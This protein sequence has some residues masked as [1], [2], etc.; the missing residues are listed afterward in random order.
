MMT[1]RAVPWLDWAEWESVRSLLVAPEPERRARGV[2]RVAAWRSRGRLPVSVETT[3]CLV[4]V[5]LS[6]RAPQPPSEVQLRLA[7]SMALLRMVNGI[8]D[9]SQRGKA[10]GSVLT[11]ARRLG[12]PPMLVDL[13]H[14]A[15]HGSLPALPAL[16]LGASQAMEWLLERYWQQQHEQATVLESDAA[17]S[18]VRRE[19]TNALKRYRK[20]RETAMQKLLDQGHELGKISQD[21]TAAAETRRCADALAGSTVVVP[22]EA[23]VE[24]FFD[25]NMLVPKAEAPTDASAAAAAGG[26]EEV[27]SLPW[28]RS[29]V[30]GVFNRLRCVWRP[31]LAAVRQ[32][33]PRLRA[34][35]LG[36][37]IDRLAAEG[38]SP[39]TLESDRDA[40]TDGLASEPLP[41][42][43]SISS[44]QR[45]RLGLLQRWAKFLMSADENLWP[46][47]QTSGGTGEA[48]AAGPGNG[49]LIPGRKGVPASELDRSEIISRC[50]H[51]MNEW[52]SPLLS[53]FKRAQQQKQ[54]QLGNSSS[55]STQQQQQHNAR[56]VA[57]SSFGC[58]IASLKRDPT[59]TIAQQ[60][61]A[62]GAGRQSP[63]AAPP[64]PDAI[65]AQLEQWRQHSALRRRQAAADAS[66]A[67]SQGQNGA[68]HSAGGIGGAAGAVGDSFGLWSVPVG[69]VP[70]ALGAP[71]PSAPSDVA[72][73]TDS[74]RA[75]VSAASESDWSLELPEF[76]NDVSLYPCPMVATSM[77]N[78]NP[79]RTGDP[80]ANGTRSAQAGAGAADQSPGSTNASYHVVGQDDPMGIDAAG[81]GGSHGYDLPAP[82]AFD[83]T[84]SLLPSNSAGHASQAAAGGRSAG[85]SAG[86]SWLQ[87]LTAEDISRHSAGASL[88]ECL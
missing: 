52:V 47:L 29:E 22:A 36:A 16:Q 45:L 21:D 11:L 66:G 24:V 79:M 13:R 81:W 2:Q 65:E 14:A 71:A 32:R 72:E 75:E 49:S 73:H 68:E 17:E 59:G 23:L 33:R 6:E 1:P 62:A 67:S 85:A 31:I 86:G 88:I 74:S 41:P 48:T 83:G 19:V 57:L 27:A 8:C 4:E 54:K 12:L 10:A 30:D 76:I 56:L 64:P 35:L 78:G 37:A 15:T 3:A 43:Q 80:A 50:L 60:S 42:P 5:W 63:T 46:P 39:G 70:T 51:G 84:E 38:G 69:Y 26:S 28:V 55:D 20:W 40:E 82:T 44:Q 53:E 61:T 34:E 18:G 9:P 58:A 7:Y 25:G 87:V 77:G